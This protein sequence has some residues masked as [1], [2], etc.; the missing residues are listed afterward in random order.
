MHQIN[1]Q[2]TI[3]TAVI[4][5]YDECFNQ[6]KLEVA[7]QLVSPSFTGLGPDGGSGPD[8]FRSNVAR[9]FTRRAWSSIVLMLVNSLKR[10]RYP[11]GSGCFNN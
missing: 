4:R 7:D 6:G 11:T 1:T 10:N 8:T 2:E 5:L 3:K 9:L